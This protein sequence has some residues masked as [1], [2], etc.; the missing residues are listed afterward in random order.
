MRVLWVCTHSF[1]VVYEL[2]RCKHTHT[3]IHTSFRALR[4]P[5]DERAFVCKTN[6][7]PIAEP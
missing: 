1:S 3:N 2:E 4:T 6:V 7:I 5:H